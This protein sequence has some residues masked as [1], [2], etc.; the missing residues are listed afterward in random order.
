MVGTTLGSPMCSRIRSTRA[1]AV[2]A[3]TI[4]IRPAHRVHSKTSFK[5]IRQISEAHVTIPTGSGKGRSDTSTRGVRF[6]NHI[7]P[8]FRPAERKVRRELSP[9]GQDL[10]DAAVSWCLKLTCTSTEKVRD[11]RSSTLNFPDEDKDE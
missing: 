2:T 4:S 8:L 9:W 6:E 5:N 10:R 7:G 11:P 1:G 3:T